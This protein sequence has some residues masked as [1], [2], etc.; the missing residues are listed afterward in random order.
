MRPS[1]AT[2]VQPWTLTKRRS[3]FKDSV[4]AATGHAATAP[5]T[6]LEWNTDKFGRS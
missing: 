1:M 4:R 5:P 3:Y 2:T 6:P